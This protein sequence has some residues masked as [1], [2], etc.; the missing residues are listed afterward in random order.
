MPRICLTA[1]SRNDKQSSVKTSEAQGFADVSVK[2]SETMT[3]I[4]CVADF[5][6]SVAQHS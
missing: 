5:L 3:H 2:T 6:R 1:N 4:K